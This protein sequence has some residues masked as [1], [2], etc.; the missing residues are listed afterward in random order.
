MEESIKWI[1]YKGKRI[2]FCNFANYDE[3][4]YLDG[5]DLM[6]KGLLKHPMGSCIPQIIDVTDSHM[7][8][9]TSDRGKRTVKV[10]AEAGINTNTA[11]L[12]ITG[13]KRIIAQAVSPV[14]NFAKGMDSAKILPGIR[15]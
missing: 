12:G 10:P 13:I 3:Q 11:I 8:A 2:M 14:V 4:M 15:I 6:E 9:K 7:T 1:E 5:V